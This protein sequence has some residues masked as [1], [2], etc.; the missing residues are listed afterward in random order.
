MMIIN[1]ACSVQG[2][3]TS[4]SVG[5]G[6]SAVQTIDR[7]INNA[8]PPM[9]ARS[10]ALLGLFVSEY[11]ALSAA[12]QGVEGALLGVG[13]QSHIMETQGNVSD[14]DYDLLQAFADALQVDVADL[15][16]RSPDRQR[17]LDLYADALSNVATK[18]NDRYKQVL[19]AADELK[20]LNREHE[21]AKNTAERDLRKALD[22]KAFSEA[23]EKQK[24]LLE[25]EQALAESDLKL[26]ELTE[27]L[28][29]L[30]KL[31]T[32]FG[33]KILAIQQN[34][35]ILISGMKVV[36]VPGIEDLKIIQRKSVSPS[37]T[38][39]ESEEFD[40]LFKQER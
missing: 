25:A 27:L 4:V 13:V 6:R 31:L 35:E 9:M 32:L 16:N 30:D 12:A 37:R 11:I 40:A 38:R 18:A 8:P 23:G 22:D 26:R 24:I 29:T 19:A 17:S 39:N 5:G 21:R 20:N 34:R 15:L 7:I 14:P 10:A 33:E 3:K 36:D 28:R 2:P 1:S